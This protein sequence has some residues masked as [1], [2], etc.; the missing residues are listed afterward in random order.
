MC[1]RLTSPE[2]AGRERTV[3][4]IL[5][6]ARDCTFAGLGAWTASA[7]SLLLAFAFGAANG[8]D[9]PDAIGMGFKPTVGQKVVQ[10]VTGDGLS[11][12]RLRERFSGTTTRQ[13]REQVA[14]PGK[15]FHAVGLRAA[16]QVRTSPPRHGRSRALAA[17]E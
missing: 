10:F 8:V 3:N 4:R 7:R 2:E 16:D 14:Q 15:R 5:R 6:L 1:C 13:L 11:R 17:D 9:R 12:R